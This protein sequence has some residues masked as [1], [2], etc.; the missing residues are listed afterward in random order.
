MAAVKFALPGLR[1]GLA[2]TSLAAGFG[3]CLGGCGDPLLGES[4]RGA[5]VWSVLIQVEPVD[6]AAEAPTNARMAMFFSPGGP[7][8]IDPEQWVELPSSSAPATVPANSLLNVFEPPGAALLAHD[9]AGAPL[10]YGIAR[11][12]AY[13]DTDGD[14]RRSP[15]E[16]FISLQSPVAYLY[17][18]APLAAGAAPT[19]GA[20]DAGF[21]YVFLPEPCGDPAPAPMTPGD[22]GVPLGARCS[23]DAD[24]AGGYCLQFFK[25]PWPAGYCTVIDPPANGCR[26][27][28]GVFVHKP[29]FNSVPPSVTGFWLRSCAKTSDCARKGDPGPNI[30]VCDPGLLACVP[31]GNG[32]LLIGA[33]VMVEPF[34]AHDIK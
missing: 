3:L 23:R 22:C 5:P 9:G 13:T 1:I 33:K 32:L 8:V 10:G 4:F 29:K 15:G 7:A 28:A 25:V 14:G 30:Y 21:R 19:R 12:I 34:C 31:R 17:T 16:A 11:V 2:I 27:A 26:P 18:P 20:L 6:P 24:C